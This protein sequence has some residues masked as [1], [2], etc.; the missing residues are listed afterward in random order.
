M[1]MWG[2]IVQLTLPWHQDAMEILGL[3]SMSKLSITNDSLQV[4]TNSS[5]PQFERRQAHRFAWLVRRSRG[6]RPRASATRVEV[7][8]PPD[9]PIAFTN[10]AD[11]ES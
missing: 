1:I 8:C 4:M 5:C 7:R 11:H 10:L 2:D 9:C 6:S 3:V